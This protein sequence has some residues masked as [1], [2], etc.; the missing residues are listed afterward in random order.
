[1]CLASL[2]THW[3]QCCMLVATTSSKMRNSSKCSGSSTHDM[4][5][6]RSCT[7]RRVP[8]RFRVRRFKPLVDTVLRPHNA[9]FAVAEPPYYFWEL[10]FLLRRLSVALCLVVFRDN[11][12]AQ[13]VRTAFA[14]LSCLVRHTQPRTAPPFRRGALS[15]CSSVKLETSR[16]TD[17]KLDAFLRAG[18]C[19]RYHCR[20]NSASIHVAVCSLL[21]FS[22][23]ADPTNPLRCFGR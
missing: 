9:L 8:R 7:R 18:R 19:H 4:V 1:M 23:L 17:A 2:R 22:S 15:Y 12:F 6:G 20:G 10:A 3:P 11:Q 13:G 21:R 16:F 14:A 5:R